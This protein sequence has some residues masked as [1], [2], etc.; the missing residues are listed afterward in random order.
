MAL[1]T[2]KAVTPQGESK[3]GTVAAQSREQAIV[4]I[5]SLGFIPLQA[6]AATAAPVPAAGQ[7]WLRRPVR[8]KKLGSNDIAEF[9]RQLSI[10]VGAG[11]PLH[12]SLDIIRSVTSH[13]ELQALVSGLQSSIRGGNS[14]SHALKERPDLFSNFYISF[15]NA[16]EISGNLGASLQDLSAYLVKARAL[17]DKLISAMIYPAILIVVTLVSIAVMM[18]FVLPKFAELFADMNADLPASTAFVLGVANALSSYGPLIITLLLIGLLLLKRQ[19]A[20]PAFRARWD[21][22]KLR[23]A[24]FGDLVRKVEMARLSRSLGTLL[25]GGV[26]ILQSVSIAGATLGNTYL[27]ALLDR[28][29]SELQDGAGLSVSLAET[30]E[31]PEFALQMIQV[32]EETGELDSTLLKVADIYDDEVDTATQRFLAIVEPAVIISL[33]LIIGGIIVSILVA[34]L[35]I[36]Q[37]PI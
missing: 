1:Y 36:N 3:Q 15:V 35:S 29:G 33:G 10:L 8:Q 31:F 16:A 37:L 21:R 5:Q 9:T 12:R 17:R 19:M 26:P 7:S 2:Y 13:A 28:A 23:I 34:V 30:G 4:K 27:A 11:L 32:G 18:V 22:L 6:E 14:L 24:V 25:R 20:S